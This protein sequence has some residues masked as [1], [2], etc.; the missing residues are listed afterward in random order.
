MSR[1]YWFK[2]VV[3]VGLT[4][5]P[6]SGQ[7]QD[8]Q[9]QATIKQE[10]SEPYSFRIP[11]EIIG[12]E[13][14]QH[15]IDDLIAQQGMNVATQAM[16]AA[17]QKMAFYARWSTIFVA[18]GTALLFWTLWVTRA[19]NRAAYDAVTATREIGE[20]QTRAYLSITSGTIEYRIDEWPIATLTVR[21]SGNSP[22]YDVQLIF[23]AKGPGGDAGADISFSD[24]IHRSQPVWAIAVDSEIEIQIIPAREKTLDWGHNPSPNAAVGSPNGEFECILIYRTIFGRLRDEFDMDEAFHFYS[25]IPDLQESTDGR[26]RIKIERRLPFTWVDSFRAPLTGKSKTGGN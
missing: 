14:S 19:A 23:V 24:C 9:R 16:N 17:T 18:I 21:N 26:Y 8:G 10:P 2:I 11:V 25:P 22:A 20:I 12:N 1:N 7:T 6:L 15:E 3:V 13:I 5:L 4:L